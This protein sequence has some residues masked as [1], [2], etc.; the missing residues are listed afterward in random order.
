[1]ENCQICK[2]SRKVSIDG[3][4]TGAVN[5]SLVVFFASN[6]AEKVFGLVFTWLDGGEQGGREVVQQST[7]LNTNLWAQGSQG[8]AKTDQ[9]RKIGVQV[10]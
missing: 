7:K 8:V 2:I 5:V 3:K 6:F 4:T 1:M 9:E 10:F